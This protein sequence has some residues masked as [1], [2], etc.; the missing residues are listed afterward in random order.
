MEH[1]PFWEEDSSSASQE[2]TL[3]LWNSGSVL[4]SHKHVTSTS[5]DLE[6][7]GPY[8]FGLF[9]NEPVYDCFP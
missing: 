2:I 1:N 3:V 4:C 9:L 5:P 6:E 7:L 8:F